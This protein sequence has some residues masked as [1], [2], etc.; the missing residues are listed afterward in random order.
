MIGRLNIVLCLLIPVLYFGL[1]AVFAP[2]YPGYSIWT[3]TASDLGAAQSPV[4]AVVSALVLGLG[5]VMTLAALTL[6]VRLR[7]LGLPLWLAC[8]PALALFSGALITFSA[9]LYP[10]PHPNHS[11]G[12]LGAGFIALP[13]VFLLS[14]WTIAGRGLRAYLVANLLAFAA[15]A[16]VMA[17]IVPLADAGL[18]GLVQKLLALTV[19]VP[20]AVTALG[21][22]RGAA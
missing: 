17:G 15:L 4:G 6:S 9:G 3:T 12:A 22:R 21:L 11:G 5:L 7:A 14:L 16:L 20:P 13:L 18:G 8:L 19:F 2:F 1:Q 10:Q